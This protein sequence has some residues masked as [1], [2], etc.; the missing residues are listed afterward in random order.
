MNA[1]GVTLGYLI[2]FVLPYSV[3]EIALTST[4]WRLPFIG[5]AVI[6]FVQLLL[7][8]FVF[9]YDTPKFYQLQGRTAEYNAVMKC[10]YSQQSLGKAASLTF[11]ILR[12]KFGQSREARELERIS[13]R[14]E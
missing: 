3:E 13:K 5:P 7:I 2:A 12:R 14:L 9:K 11:R 8:L 4:M 1:V 6:A 10:I